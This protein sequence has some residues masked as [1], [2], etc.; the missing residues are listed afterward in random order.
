V[1]SKSECPPAEVGVSAVETIYSAGVDPQETLRTPRAPGR[2][3]ALRLPFV[4]PAGYSLGSVFARGGN[5]RV[6]RA[7][8]NHLGRMVAIKELLQRGGA[9]EDRFVREAFITAKLQHPAIVPIYQ[10][11]R[12]PSGE[13]FY[14][15]KLVSG[16]A[17][18]DLIEQLPSIHRRTP[19]LR[20]VL[21]A[22]EAVAYAHAQG[23]IHR[24]L[25][26]DNVLVGEFGETVVI[27]WGLAKELGEVEAPVA[28]NLPQSPQATGSS[29]QAAERGRA[30]DGL[31]VVGSIM[32]TPAYMPPEQAS[33][34]T[35]DERSDVYA[36]GAILYHVLAG[37]PPYVGEMPELLRRVLAQAPARLGERQP[38]LPQDLVALVEKA[39]ARDPAER[40]P[41]AKALA[42]DLQRYLDGEPIQAR[43][44]TVGYVIRKKVK[45][46]KTLALI[47]SAALVLVV[48]LGGVALR[49]RLSAA[50][51]ASLAQQLGQDVTE[52]E[53]FLRYA[54]G[55]PLH[56]ATREKEIV[57]SRMREIGARMRQI[58]AAA[59]GPGNYALGRGY[60]SLG[61]YEEADGH[62]SQAWSHGYRKPEVAYALG[63]CRGELYNHMMDEAQRIPDTR[64]RQARIK[65]AETKYLE[66][67]LL[68]LRESRAAQT[69]MESP[70][71]LEGLIAFYGKRYEEALSKVEEAWRASPWLGEA[72]KLEGD[73][74]HAKANAEKQRGSY[75][76]ALRDY[77]RAAEAYRAAEDIARSDAAAYEAESQVWLETLEMA[78]ERGASPKEFFDNMI[79]AS[80]K[81][82]AAD[83]ESTRSYRRKAIAHWRLGEH[84]ALT[85]KDPSSALSSAVVAALEAIR[86]D[87]DDAGTL[88]ALGNI[89]LTKAFDEMSKGADPRASLDSAVEK[90]RRATVARPL[91]AWAWNDM[92]NA[93]M[94]KG[95]YEAEHGIDPRVSFDEASGVYKRAAE[96]DPSYVYPLS[97]MCLVRLHYGKYE[98]S[99]GLDPRPTLERAAVS[100]AEARQRNPSYHSPIFHLAESL[101]ERA[102][103]ERDSGLD[104][105]GTLDRTVEVLTK[106]FSGS[107]D[108]EAY[109]FLGSVQRERALYLLA[110][111]QDPTE[112]LRQGADIVRKMLELVP[113]EACGQ[114]TGGLLASIAA[115]WE[116]MQR[117]APEPHFKRAEE[118]FARTLALPLET[119]RPEKLLAVAEL[120]RIEAEW[121]AN[122]RGRA[123]ESLGLG[124][125]AADAALKINPR[126]SKALA[127]RGELLLLAARLE[128][129][130]ERVKER[131]AAALASL[132]EAVKQNPG[133][134]RSLGP[135][136]DKARRLTSEE[137]SHPR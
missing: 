93:M 115:R 37:E 24:D 119:T 95:D 51:Q 43:Q 54:H 70:V 99:I 32:G 92:G 128:R 58:G 4:D 3:D 102:S 21:A 53:L 111:G 108:I 39:M 127:V 65:E 40:Y 96:L 55:L 14:A 69:K 113:S 20:H 27:D 97:N 66:P 38:T 22:A 44:A 59:E 15:M 9:A 105:R 45:K 133:S 63:L 135:A 78:K 6:L 64:A 36:L 85:G 123:T 112:V 30:S 5:G 57:L 2:W 79:H 56:D 124:L 13:P 120:H 116:A 7:C 8:D 16:R 68:L 94:V 19:L 104:P 17:L 130:P 67:A 114:F 132:L 101:V 28:D 50:T 41:T 33:G 103:Y 121:Y 107:P 11:G 25:K 122:P 48:V 74:F 82:L 18:T 52:M 86:R 26:P 137:L 126:M 91:F 89:F 1:A 83:P 98:A 125:A 131:A 90:G 62:L 42:E 88:D 71:Y 31:T 34:R 81:A 77:R 106:E 49:T 60:L 129:A 75:D 23:V 10:A 117:K 118:A 110:Q 46:H 109:C 35:A 47:A 61:R 136:I 100:C 72:K 87:P 12:W 84:Q 134:E 76:E 80:D 29:D 73:V